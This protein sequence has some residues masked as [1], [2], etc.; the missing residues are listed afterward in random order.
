MKFWRRKLPEEDISSDKYEK[1]N[2]GYVT[3]FESAK[4]AVTEDRFL[5]HVYTGKQSFSS[6]I[7][8]ELL[9]FH[10]EKII[11][12]G[13]ERQG[14]VR[15]SI[16][17]SGENLILPAL[18]EALEGVDGYGGGHEYACGAAVKKEDFKKFVE[19]LKGLF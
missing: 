3:L 19:R 15:M 13:R 4:N 6:E 11:I 5:I 12:I 1:I 17:G 2:A 10:P 9:H 14:E 8:N 16:R 7:A 18:K